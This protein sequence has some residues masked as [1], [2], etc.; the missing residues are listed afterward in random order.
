MKKLFSMSLIAALTLGGLMFGRPAS[1]RSEDTISVTGDAVV[2]VVPDEVSIVLGVETSDLELTVAKKQNDERILRVL[3]VAKQ[4]DI[5]PEQIQTDFINIEPRYTSDYDKRTFLG[6]FVRKTVV[7]TLRD[8]KRFDEVLSGVLEAGANYVQGIEFRTTELRKYRDQ[9]RS[10]AIKAAK[11]KAEVLAGELGRVV[12]RPISIQENGFGWYSSYG[13]YWGGRYGGAQS[14][15]VMQNAGGTAPN[16]DGST[17]APGQIS[18]NA[19]V[20][21][22]FELGDRAK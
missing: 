21:V 10:L 2:K 7:L 1:A 11:E 4:F 15:N 12:K 17:L 13:S 3:A 18:I 14:Q 5:K 19:T 6:Y 8:I 20:S 16:G 22:T 9:A